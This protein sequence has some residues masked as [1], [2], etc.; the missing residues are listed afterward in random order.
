MYNNYITY[1]HT[2]NNNNFANSYFKSSNKYKSVLE[3]VSYEQGLI[4]LKQINT[5]FTN[6]NIDDIKNYIKIN[7]RV[8]NPNVYSY[9]IEQYNEKIIASPSSLRYIYH[10]LLI[11]KHYTT[12]KNQN[13]VEVG[14]GY[15]GLFL[16]ICFFKNKFSITIDKYYFIDLPP[17]CN[18]I[19]LYLN[20]N[21]EF[22]NINYSIVNSQNYGL[23]IIDNNLFLI[24]NYCFTELDNYNR[25]KYI[26]HLLPKVS[27]GFILW[28]TIFKYDINNAYK[29]FNNETLQI[30]E[31][32]PQTATAQDKNYHVFF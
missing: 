25:E 10:S 31:E 1:L 16:A 29:L 21:K 26:K 4:Y 13:I 9:Y 23:D 15:G 28:Q 8:G 12:K 14:C 19:S 7:D 20:S 6:V 30:E 27:C 18:L 3:H 2:L 32:I 22:I 11:L 5:N 24:S 17:V